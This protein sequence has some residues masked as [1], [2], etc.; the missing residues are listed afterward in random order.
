VNDRH[1]FVDRR[2]E[3]GSKL[4]QPVLLFLGYGDPGRQLTPQDFVLDLEVA[5]LPGQLFLGRAGDQQQQGLK[6]VLHC[7]RLGER[8][9]NQG[10]SHFCTPVAAAGNAN[11]AR[12]GTAHMISGPNVAVVLCGLGRYEVDRDG[13]P[14]G[15]NPSRFKQY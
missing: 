7:G 11:S 13:P 4:R 8:W 9:E 1:Q 12:A 10:R 5:D 14:V 3:L 6:Q 2:S 15:E